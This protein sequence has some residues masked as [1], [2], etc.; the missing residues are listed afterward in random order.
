VSPTLLASGT[1]AKSLLDRCWHWGIGGLVLA[2]QTSATED[3]K[4]PP[5]A[6]K[7]EIHIPMATILKVVGSGLGLWAVFLLWPEFLLFLISVLFA[8]TLNPVVRW[9]ETKRIRRGLG[10]VIIAILAIGLMTVFVVFALPPLA[11]QITHLLES[12]P[13]FRAQ[14][15]SRI[16]A[17]YPTIQR[18]IHELFASTSS[19]EMITTLGRWFGWGRGA[20]TGLVVAG[21]VLVLTLYL[22]LHGRSLYAWALAFV[23]RTHR[24]KLAITMDE[25][26]GVVHAFV[27]GQVLVAVLFAIFT[28]V[29][30]SI[31]GVPAVAPLAII[32]GLCDVVP[33]LGIVL[34]TVPAV[35]LALV[36]SPGT[37]VVVLLAYVAYHLFET[38]VLLPRVYGNKLKISS[39][40][41]LLALLVGGRLQGILGAVLALPLVAAYPIVERHW[42]QRYLAARVLMDHKALAQAAETGSEVAI[43]SVLHGEKHASEGSGSPGGNE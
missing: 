6:D 33:V 10:V 41:V 7:R 19:P 31:L 11:G 15:L 18:V 37:A 34:A 29:L 28:A 24:E 17:R 20:V 30:L 23:P 35:L 12:L 3:I 2:E 14:V 9:M 8:V 43:D 40:A 4:A 39:L 1:L 38:Y 27:S 16:P 21:V 25:V 42:L 36:V 26:S 5:I 32:A 13:G 22:L